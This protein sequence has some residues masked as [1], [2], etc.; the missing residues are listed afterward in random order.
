M[1]YINAELLREEIEKIYKS[2]IQPWLSGVSPKSVIYEYVLPLIDSLQQEQPEVDLETFDK[3][4]TK[5][6]GRCAAEPNDTIACLHIDSFIDVARHFFNLGCTCT[7]EK[8]DEIEHNRQREE[9]SVPKDLEEAATITLDEAESVADE[10]TGFL[11]KGLIE[12]QPRPIG[13]KW[14]IEYARKRFIT[15]AE[16]QAEHA[17]LPE[18]TVLFNKGVE[19]GKRLMMEDAVEGEFLYTPYP[20]IALDDCKDYNFKDN[21][22]VRIIIVKEN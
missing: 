9:E 21:Q 3:S 5:M 18:D 14:F 20:T 8:Y 11:E 2:E 12:N 1:K 10:Y 15:G 19:E 16:W 6:W 7:A 22:K 13:G 17:P 4:V